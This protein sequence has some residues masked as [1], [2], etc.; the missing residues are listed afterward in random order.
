[1]LS[2]HGWPNAWAVDTSGQLHWSLIIVKWKLVLKKMN[3]LTFWIPLHFCKLGQHQAVPRSYVCLEGADKTSLPASAVG[4][5]RAAGGL[6]PVTLLS[7]QG[8]VNSI[9]DFSLK[10]CS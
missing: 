10:I 1:M 4:G 5:R 6:Q 9:L 2:S 3:T 8:L 7:S